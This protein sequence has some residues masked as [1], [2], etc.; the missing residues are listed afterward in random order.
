M[1][2]TMEE[3]LTMMMRE[4]GGPRNATIRK[5]CREALGKLMISAIFLCQSASNNTGNCS[6][7]PFHRGGM[8]LTRIPCMTMN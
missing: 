6:T 2:M 5:T 3:I 1:V 8:R 7:V 4:A